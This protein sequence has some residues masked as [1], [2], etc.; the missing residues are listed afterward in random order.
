MRIA[1]LSSDPDVVY[2][3]GHACP[4][5]LRGL[6]HALARA[7]HDVTLILSGLEPGCADPAPELALRTLRMPVSVREID[8]HFSRIR[9][10]V[11]IERHVPG[12]LEGATAA[13]EAGVPHLYDLESVPRLGIGTSLS[14]R[15]ALPEALALSRGALVA[16]ERAAERLRALMG[17]EF[18]VGVVANAVGEAFLGTP[19]HDQVGRIERQ[20]RL[21]PHGSR[22]ACYGPLVRD[23]G[24]V[25]LVSALG[26]LPAEKRPRLVV[27]GDGPERNPALAAADE[28][29]VGLV[30]CGSVPQRD[31]PAY[32]ALCDLVVVPGD[33]DEGVP[34]SLVEAMA[35]RRAVIASATDAA[36]RVARHGHDALLVPFGEPEA[37]AGALEELL[38]DGARRERLGAQARRAVATRHTWEARTEPVER[39]VDRVRVM[40]GSAVETWQPASRSAGVDG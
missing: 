11:V 32:L 24:L 38:A 31:A 23:G 36:R 28:A 14:V 34:R 12:S 19:A 15:G 26:L 39:L 9:P 20:L 37:L 5:R 13:A 18:E 25:P 27:I 40:G 8:W 2:G 21:S 35:M 4:V 10:D 16:D 33:E 29:Q 7:G 1:L 6:A 30:L 3:D 17:V 22:I